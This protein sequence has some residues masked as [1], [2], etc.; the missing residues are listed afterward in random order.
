MSREQQQ[1]ALLYSV[2]NVRE[3]HPITNADG[4]QP[5]GMTFT[6][7]AQLSLYQMRER[8]ALPH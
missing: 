3:K 6:E 2:E 8:A 4:G 7:P 5:S 1:H